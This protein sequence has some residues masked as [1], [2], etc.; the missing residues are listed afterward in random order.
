M[1]RK[2]IIDLVNNDILP[3]VNHSWAWQDM[4]VSGKELI[5][6][7]IDFRK[8]QIKSGTAKADDVLTANVI[9]GFLYINNTPIKRIAPKDPRPAFDEYSYYMEGKILARQGCID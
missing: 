9:D 3:Q 1:T 7:V 5:K 4:F 2:D 6:L 8:E